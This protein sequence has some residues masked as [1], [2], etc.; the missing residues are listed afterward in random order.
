[1]RN[2]ILLSAIVCGLFIALITVANAK[3]DV[4]VKVDANGNAVGDAIMCDAGTCGAGSQ[5]SQLTLQAGEQYVLQGTG[6]AGIGNN[7]PNTQ[8]KV[9][10]QTNDWTVTR[11]SHQGVIVDQTIQTTTTEKFN[12]VQNTPSVIKSEI[13]IIE[14]NPVKKTDLYSTETVTA[15]TDVDENDLLD[16]YS[17]NWWK[18]FISWLDNL[19][20]SGWWF[21]P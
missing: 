3:A 7:N 11:Q 1:M 6:Q 18:V 4:Y 8:V 15:T 16:I 21:T 14:T 20:V 5:F 2:R 12:P 17:P 13:A 19:F 10:L 9:D